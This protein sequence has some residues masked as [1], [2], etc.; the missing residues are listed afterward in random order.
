MEIFCLVMFHIV[1]LN[2]HVQFYLESVVQAYK[3]DSGVKFDRNIRI[4]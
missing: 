4:V 3:Y 1:L 2:H